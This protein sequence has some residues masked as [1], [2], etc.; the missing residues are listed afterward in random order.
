MFLRIEKVPR[1]GIAGNPDLRI[2]IPKS[3]NSDSI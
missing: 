2:S 1:D 3:P